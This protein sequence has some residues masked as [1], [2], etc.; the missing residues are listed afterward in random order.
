MNQALV[1]CPWCG[2]DPLYQRYHDQE[3][4]VPLRDERRLFEMLVLE[5]AQLGTWSW[6]V[7]SG[8]SSPLTGRPKPTGCCRIPVSCATA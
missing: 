1:R 5:G 7:I 3:W 8:K 2:D 6:D 4:G